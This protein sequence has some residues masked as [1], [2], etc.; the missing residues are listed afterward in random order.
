MP[1]ERGEERLPNLGR[2]GVIQFTRAGS[3]AERR[4]PGVRLGTWIRVWLW[5][6]RG[7]NGGGSEGTRSM[8]RS[9]SRVKGLGVL[10]K[11]RDTLK[12]ALNGRGGGGGT[13][14]LSR[15]SRFEE[16]WKELW[17]LRLGLVSGLH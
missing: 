11:S 16:L 15:C 8:S 9:M 1:A 13:S 4:I 5:Q 12:G 3:R 6:V 17:K 10:S 2:R 14:S 7:I